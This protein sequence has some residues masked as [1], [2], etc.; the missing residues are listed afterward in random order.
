MADK[1]QSR[2]RERLAFGRPIDWGTEGKLG[3]V[4]FGT[5]KGDEFPPL[6]VGNVKRLI[7]EGFLDRDARH[8][9]AP[10]AGRLVDWADY[11]R[12]KYR[13]F[14]FE[15]G[16][17]G[18][19]VGPHRDDARIRLNGV[20]ISS[21]GPLPRRLKREGAREFDP[22]FLSANTYHLDILWD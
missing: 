17:V 16:L 18:Y 5:K 13:A 3:T 9:E 15:I 10:P 7:E 8:N 19:M 14:Q 4:F 12:D 22:D 11:I 2:R 6:P 1:K 21:Q 20:S